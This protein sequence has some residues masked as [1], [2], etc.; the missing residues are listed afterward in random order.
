M[1][2][3]FYP[4]KLYYKIILAEGAAMK[5]YLVQHGESLDKEIDPDQPLSDKGISDIEKLGHFLSKNKI[6]INHIIHSGKNRAEQTASILAPLLSLSKIEFYP[7]LGPL[8]DLNF[9][10]MKS[11]STNTTYFLSATCPFYVN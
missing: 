1:N 7:N 3:D 5:I 6:E 4:V 2:A 9:L 8:D 10:Q 11:T